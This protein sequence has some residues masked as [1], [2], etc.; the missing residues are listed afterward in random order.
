MVTAC[1][2]IE[3]HWL[4]NKYICGDEIS[5]ADILAASELEQPSK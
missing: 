2:S 4:K 1:D 5:I 3:N